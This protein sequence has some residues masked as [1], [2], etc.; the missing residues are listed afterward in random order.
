MY[1]LKTYHMNFKGSVNH[2]E[3]QEKNPLITSF[4][5]IDFRDFV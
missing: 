2:K 3:M 1:L 4:L 5:K